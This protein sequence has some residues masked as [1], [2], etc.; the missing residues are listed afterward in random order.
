[1]FC[2]I[3][4]YYD[5]YYDVMKKINLLQFY[6]IQISYIHI[7]IVYCIGI[8]KRMRIE[9]KNIYF[10]TVRDR[11]RKAPLVCIDTYFSLSLLITMCVCFV[12]TMIYYITYV[13]DNF[14]III[15]IKKKSH[16]NNRRFVITV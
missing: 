6:Y 12:P 11:K 4:I 14:F 2:C 10:N 15:I 9:Q 7:I 8:L 3:M 16:S 5:I 13:S 1:M